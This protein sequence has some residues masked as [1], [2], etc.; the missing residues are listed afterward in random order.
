MNHSSADA[1]TATLAVTVQV[2]PSLARCLIASTSATRPT[3]EA[4]AAAQSQR[5]CTASRSSGSRRAPTMSRTA[6]TGR[7][8]RNTEPHQKRS[9]S[10]PPTIGP[11][12]APP[13]AIALHKPMARVRSRATVK[14][15]RMMASVDGMMVAPPTPMS[16]RAAMSHS[17][18][19]AKAASAEARPKIAQ[20]ASSTRLRPR[21]SLRAPADTSKPASTSE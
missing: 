21:R 20:P 10:T 6:S 16:T 9:S 4:S 3:I 2:R 11:T 5:P 13:A 17:A 8:I 18:D 14:I 7:L 12:A 19:G 15:E 1:A